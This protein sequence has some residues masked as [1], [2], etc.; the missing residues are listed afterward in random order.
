LGVPWVF[1]AFGTGFAIEPNGKGVLRLNGRSKFTAAQNRI[2]WLFIA[3]PVLLFF[4]FTFIPLVMAV[5]FSF[6]S[7]D[8]INPPRFIGFRNF[9]RIWTDEFFWIALR[10]TATYALLYV[11]SGLVL[12]LSVALFVNS[13]RKFV[14]LYRMLFYLPVLSSSVANATLWSWIY[15]PKM[16]LLNGLLS[17]FGIAGPSWLNDTKTAMF[18]I[19]I[20]SLWAGF[21]GNMMIFL[22]ALKGVPD[23][24]YEAAVIDGA[25][26]WQRFSRIT[27]PSI[28]KTTFFVSTM[29]II[30]TFQVFDAAFLLTSG[31]PGNATITMVYYIYNRGFKDLK[32]GY[33]SAMSLCLFAIIF[34]FSLMN[35]KVNKA[36]D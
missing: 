24:L 23:V 10:N 17:L 5:V 30:G 6:T 35:M 3:P 27:V 7:Y 8:I 19:V 31:G 1:V 20:M 22:A 12:S 21:A 29:L 25:N 16:G 33:A 32:M 13:K 28:R 2:G 18:A 15:N 9:Q 26:R 34:V 36:K 4:L 11:P 14:G